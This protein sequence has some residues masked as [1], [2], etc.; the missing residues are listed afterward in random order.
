MTR[1]KKGLAE[2]V[3][4]VMTDG[5]I[6]ADSG[7]K[8]L[9]V[10]P[11]YCAMVGYTRQELQMMNIRDLE[12]ELSLSEADRRIPQMLQQ[13]SGRLV[14]NHRCKDGRSIELDMS[15][16]ITRLNK[17]R[18]IAAFVRP[19]DNPQPIGDTTLDQENLYLTLVKTD[20]DAVTVSDLDGKITFVSTR[21]LDLHRYSS[22]DQLL[23]KSAFDFIA[24]EDRARAVEN[25]QKTLT[26]G[27]IRNIEYCLLRS[28][29]SRF[30]GELHA[31]VV[32]DAEG[33]PQAFIATT[34]DITERKQAEN[35]L[36]ESEE[37]FRTLADYSPNNIFINKNGKV[38]YVNRKCEEMM[39]YTKDEILSED[40]DF[41]T[42]I[43]PQSKDL[44]AAAFGEHKKGKEVPPYEYSL[45][46]KEGKIFYAIITTKLIQ[47][48]GG[49]AILGVVTDISD[50]KK[51]E[52][53]L[54][55]TAQ[56]LKADREALQEKNIALKQFLD[57][58]EKER[59]NYKHHISQEFSRAV[60]PILKHLKDKAESGHSKKLQTLEKRLQ[61]ILSRDIDVFQDGLARLSPSEVKVCELV[62]NG[63]SS[64]Q[65]SNALNVS[66]YTVHKHREQI[67]KKLGICN[68]KINLTTYLRTH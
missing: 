48:E 6:L 58:I 4:Q 49:R 35:A 7:G 26:H 15:F 24:P 39:G 51:V 57:T 41:R 28:D 17:S 3:F 68:T 5:Y 50:R 11:A 13:G 62:K 19:V 53:A 30:I 37:K 67:R 12:I 38:V 66:L 52:E 22:P 31:S 44:V 29:G 42:L 46:T 2:E 21:T 45:M 14:T 61:M 54:K 36:K 8:I 32:R 55:K 16:A 20:P 33:R 18:Q 27:A 1:T 65:I 40:F 43:A 34:R 25:M 56:Q 47:Y 23:G 64:K 59:Q 60:M 63:M 10:N 9:D